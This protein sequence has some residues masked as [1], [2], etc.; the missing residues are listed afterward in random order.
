M[1]SVRME[2]VK[3]EGVEKV[4]VVVVVVEKVVMAAVATICSCPLPID[5]LG[6]CIHV[7]LYLHVQYPST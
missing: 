3:A 7:C 4:V 2:S 6:Q 5:P 1:E